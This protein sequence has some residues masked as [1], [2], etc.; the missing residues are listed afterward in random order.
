VK[1]V[2]TIARILLGL[3]FLVFGLNGFLL[4]MPPP[5]SIPAPAGPFSEAMQVSH[6]TW[7][8]SGVQV[9][10]GIM[11]LT[12]QYVP[13]AIVTL[14]A[15]LANI[16]VFHLTM[17]PMGL[18]LAIV[19]TVLWFVVAWPLRAHFAPLFVRRA[20]TNVPA[21]RGRENAP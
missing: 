12:N 18:P 6:Y 9:I 10:A 11:L 16:L 5:P 2:H 20:D 4:F 13:L 7:F 3:A 21:A 14:A 15:V 1:I 8:V 17:L 19:V